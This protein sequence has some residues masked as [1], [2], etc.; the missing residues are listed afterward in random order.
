MFSPLNLGN[1]V[2]TLTNIILYVTFKAKSFKKKKKK[3]LC[4]LHLYWKVSSCSHE[5]LCHKS[6]FKTAMMECNHVDL[7]INIPSYAHSSVILV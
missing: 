2:P 4:N 6:N 1:I 7:P 3:K 5:E